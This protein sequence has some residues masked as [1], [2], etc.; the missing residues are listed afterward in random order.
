MPMS[1]HPLAEIF[2][3]SSKNLSDKAERYRKLKLCPYHNTIPSC[4]KNSAKHPL[5]VCSIFEK[6][7]PVI[8]CPIRFRE[9]WTIIEDAA[10]F[11]SLPQRILPP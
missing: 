4:T 10:Q 6:D 5:G 2:G 11:F 1:A 8:T 9:D 3:F 7:A